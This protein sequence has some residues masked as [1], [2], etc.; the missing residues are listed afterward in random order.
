MVPPRISRARSLLKD[1]V[2]P[3]LELEMMT[4]RGEIISCFELDLRVEPET[5]AESFCRST[6]RR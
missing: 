2:V 4:D 3:A 1:D 5:T 6:R